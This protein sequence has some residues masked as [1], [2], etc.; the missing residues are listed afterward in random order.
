MKSR[1]RRDAAPPESTDSKSID[2][3]YGLEP[4]FEPGDTSDVPTRLVRL[5]CPYC[6]ET[7]DTLMDLSA[8]S[9]R[10]IEDCQVCCQPIEMTGEVDAGGALLSVSA[11][12]S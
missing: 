9:F 6:G 1:Q 3:L 10:Y 8:G 11:D 7:I 2:E 5:Q 4:I 12:R